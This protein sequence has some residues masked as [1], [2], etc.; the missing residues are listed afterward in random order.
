MRYFLVGLSAKVIFTFTIDGSVSFPFVDV[1]GME[2]IGSAFGR[3]ASDSSWLV[4]M[5]IYLF[6]TLI[7]I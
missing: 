3:T 7:F 2:E 6:I 5:F 1:E 4:E